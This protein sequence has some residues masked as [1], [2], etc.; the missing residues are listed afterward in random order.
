MSASNGNNNLEGV[1]KEQK[2]LRTA[3][4]QLNSLME[5]M[6]L[7]VGGRDFP[8][9][10]DKGKML[11]KDN[12]VVEKEFPVD[13][14][15]RYKIVNPRRLY[16]GKS[17]SDWTT[18]WFNWFISA[19]ADRRNS[20]PVV[21]TRSHG[22]PNST[23]GAFASDM[24][25]QV[26]SESVSPTDSHIGDMEYRTT[27]FNDPNVR[28]GS[29]RLQI[30]EDQIVF[31]PISVAYAFG[32]VGQY[33]FSDWGWMQDFTGSTI[34]YGDNPPEPSQFTINNQDIIL[35]DHLTMYDFRISTPIFTTVVPEAQYGRSLK[36][37]TEDAP[38]VP[39]SYPTL[40][41]GYFVMLKF[42][43]GS[44]W[45]HSWSSAPRERYVPYFSEQLYQIEVRERRGKGG[46]PHKG[47]I[48]EA[49][50]NTRH[51][52]SGLSKER[53]TI[54]RPSGNERVF[55][56]I[57]YEKKKTGELTEPEIRRFRRFISS[58]PI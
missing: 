54:V 41:E 50:A 19:D 48:T 14:E 7:F 39:G 51:A 40:V 29:D 5:S 37:F 47:L 44:Y 9:D 3:I 11:D 52:Y 28:I 20:G 31:V 2:E 23:T 58:S 22:L 27:Y 21:F 24:P 46:S 17:Y 55:N 8:I 53:A 32:S 25:S 57:F 56:R 26:T 33:R 34:D 35:P 15:G 1:L 4:D 30:F 45:V 38:I 42:E 10:V 12:K 6:K 49:L 43:P 18:D 13:G 36:D 16:R